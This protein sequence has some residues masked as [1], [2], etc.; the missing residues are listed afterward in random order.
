[1]ALEKVNARDW[2]T[3]I[4]TGT[5]AVPVW[6]QIAGINNFVINRGTEKTPTT[7]FDSGGT[8]EHHAM[9]RSKTLGLEGRRLEDP[10]DGSLDPGQEAVET[11]ADAVGVASLKQFQFISPGGTIRTAKFSAEMGGIGGGN[12]DKTSWGCTIERSGAEAIS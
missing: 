10:A 9:E 1:M 4:N 11:L 6:T 12:N 5:E 8:A 7:D 2:V 3:N